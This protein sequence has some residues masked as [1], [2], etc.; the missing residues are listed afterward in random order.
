MMLGGKQKD[1]NDKG[2]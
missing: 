1:T 2:N